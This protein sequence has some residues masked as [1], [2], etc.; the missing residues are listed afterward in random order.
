MMKALFFC[1]SK[2]SRPY[3]PILT[4]DLAPLPADDSKFSNAS[5]IFHKQFDMPKDEVLVNCM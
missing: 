5:L 4:L 3:T 1:L 2:A